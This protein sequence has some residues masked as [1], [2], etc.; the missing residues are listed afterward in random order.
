MKKWE[1]FVSWV[2]GNRKIGS[3]TI[4]TR[5]LARKSLEKEHEDLFLGVETAH[6]LNDWET[7]VKARQEKLTS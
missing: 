1:K 7:I 6:P 4:N 3:I 2:K 5:E